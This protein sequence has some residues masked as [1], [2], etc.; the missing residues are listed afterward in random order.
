MNII[1]NKSEI[2]G[3]KLRAKAIDIIEFGIN[4]VLP[5]VLM[6]ETVR[7]D[8]NFNSLVVQ[9]NTFNMLRGRI[10]VVG[11][12]KATGAMAK[13]LEAIINAE[14][15]TAGVVNSIDKC[16]TEI[17]KVNKAGHP[18]PDKNGVKGVEE[19]LAIK[20][21]YKLE[22]NDLV[23]CLL[24]GGG[25]VLLPALVKGI[26]LADKQKTTDV[27]IKSGADINEI[28]TVRKHLS[29]IKGGRLGEYF[30]P[31][32]VV[33][34]IISDVV[35]DKLE[36]IA[37][38]PTVPDQGTFADAILVIEKYKLA[39]R[40]PASVWNYLQEGSSGNKPETPKE[41]ANTYNYI[42]GNNSLALE[43]MAL[44]AK[45]LGLRPIIVGADM[46]GDTALAAEKNAKAIIAG[47]YSNYDCILFGG[48]TTPSLPERHGKGGRNTH[49]VAASLKALAS[50][51]NKWVMASVATDGVDYFSKA[52]G[53]I[54]DQDTSGLL[55]SAGLNVSKYLDDYDSYNLFNKLD[56]SLIKTG[57][58]NTNVGDVVVYLRE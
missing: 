21:K 17:I 3:S 47:R 43:N 38:G 52:A 5:E 23:I 14:N 25:S 16:K 13:K 45:Q 32:I 28:N 22:S 31:A 29:R 27:L 46:A 42:I 24:S 4:S 1:K 53:A 11:G 50:L 36:V 41:L 7:Y 15:I 30:K 10:F 18:I 51:G 9:T 34:I 8:K 49:Y 2:S 58:T 6:D 37:S 35:G 26:S 54:I 44:R 19:M 55:E 39:S 56:S 20:D 48:E 33:S 57:S 12:G 40:I